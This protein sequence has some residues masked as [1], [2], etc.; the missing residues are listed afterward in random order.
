[1]NDRALGDAVHALAETPGVFDDGTPLDY[2]WGVRILEL[3]GRRTVSHGCSWPTWSAKAIL[4]RLT[5]YD[6]D[7]SSHAE[8]NL[9]AE[10][11]GLDVC[12]S[13]ELTGD[14]GVRPWPSCSLVGN[15]GLGGDC[16][17][18]CRG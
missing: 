3:A 15:P 8:V 11:V 7:R 18:S 1:M 10:S 12:E 17:V 16:A 13:L 5:Q 2:A 6:Q 9:A 4:P 14:F